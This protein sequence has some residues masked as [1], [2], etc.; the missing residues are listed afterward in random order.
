MSKVERF[1]D[2]KVWQL[3]RELCK[4]VHAE[5]LVL[6]SIGRLIMNTSP[7]KNLIQH[8]TKHWNAEKCLKVLSFI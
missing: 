7:M 6:N 1:E 4:E 8:S 2:L 5:K 3:A